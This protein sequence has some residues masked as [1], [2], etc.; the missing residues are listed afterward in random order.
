MVCDG[1]VRKIE[2]HVK[3][4]LVQSFP[5]MNSY[6]LYSDEPWSPVAI[7]FTD[8]K[9]GDRVGTQHEG[10]IVSGSAIVLGGSE[11][12]STMVKVRYNNGYLTHR[13]LHELFPWRD[14]LE[15]GDRV[16]V[17][18]HS[19]C[20]TKTTHA[21][22]RQFASRWM[23][24]GPYEHPGML[25]IERCLG[26]LTHPDFDRPCTDIEGVYRKIKKIR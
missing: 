20:E 7:G 4:H 23:P 19:I 8:Y 9:I 3:K 13:Y 17:S 25:A 6:D 5:F 14:G 11:Q 15:R 21:Q 12:G 22:L 18:L 16:P 2:T 26:L 1:S 10:R 24:S